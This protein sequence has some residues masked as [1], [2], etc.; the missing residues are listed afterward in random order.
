MHPAL[1]FLAGAL[2]S[3]LIR[4]EIVTDKP[5]PKRRYDPIPPNPIP[6]STHKVV[7]C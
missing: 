4:I 3:R 5:K 7:I 1:W 2:A 6:R